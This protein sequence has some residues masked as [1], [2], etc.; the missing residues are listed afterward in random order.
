MPRHTGNTLAG[1]A[2]ASLR[3]LKGDHDGRTVWA[4]FDWLSP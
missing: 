3:E 2:G 1:A 4:R